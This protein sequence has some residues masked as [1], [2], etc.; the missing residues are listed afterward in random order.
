MVKRL[1]MGSNVFCVDIFF[2]CLKQKWNSVNKG[3]SKSWK[4]AS[5]S[6]GYYANKLYSWRKFDNKCNV[7]WNLH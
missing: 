5:F 7:E 4:P 1:F 6:L 3:I 2:H